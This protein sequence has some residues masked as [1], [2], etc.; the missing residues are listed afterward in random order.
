[1]LLLLLLMLLVATGHF[2]RISMSVAGTE[3][4]IPQHGISPTA[5]GWVYTAYLIVYTLCMTPG[6]LFIDRFGPK[7]ALLIVLGGSAVFTALTGLAGLLF[8]APAAL[9]LALLVVRSLMGLCNAPQH[10]GAAHLVGNWVAP[11]GRNLANG[12]VNFAALVGISCT[13]VVFGWLIDRFDWTGAALCTSGGTLLLAAVWALAASDRPEGAITKKL[14]VGRPAPGGLKL[15]LRNRSLVFLTIS[16]AL[17]GYFQYLFFYWAQYYFER[18]EVPTE[19]S[20]VYTSLLAL[21]NGVGMVLGGWLTDTVRARFGGR[22]LWTVVPAA[23]LLLGAAALLPG[24]YSEDTLVTFGCFAL[25]MMVVGGSEG[26][27]WTLSVELGGKRGGTAAGIL[28]TGGNAGGL[29]APVVTPYLSL[30][31]GWQSGFVVAGVFCVLAALCWVW[32]DPRERIAEPNDVG[33]SETGITL[34]PDSRIRSG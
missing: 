15:L 8:A 11:A 19:T 24:I 30:L 14:D 26:S 21:A 2:N 31:F 29:A 25:A 18:R 9:W 6:G 34:P 1:L 16:Y 28:N 33:G 13:Y 27:F 17:A 20:R 5:M 12:L 4:L 32:I 22:R 10:P 3:R 23:C 7:R